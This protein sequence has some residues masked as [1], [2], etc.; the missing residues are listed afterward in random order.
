M[1]GTD[2]MSVDGI[3]EHCVAENK[4]KERSLQVSTIF[5]PGVKNEQANA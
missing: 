1:F 3:H 4:R 2:P 5:S